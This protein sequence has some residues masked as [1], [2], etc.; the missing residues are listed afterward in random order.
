MLTICKNDKQKIKELVNKKGLNN[1]V[2]S[3]SNLIDDIILAM[4]RDGIIDCLDRS[5][6][7]KRK[8]NSHVPFKLIIA[9]SIAAKMRIHT[10]LTDIPV[11]I[12]DHRV[13][14]ELGY[15]I[16]FDNREELFTEGTIRHLLRMPNSLQRTARFG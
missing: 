14:A 11:A 7:D 13:L 4:Y 5:F 9:L 15:N 16:V 10:S 1:I 12:K 3:N 2:I 6:F 8:H